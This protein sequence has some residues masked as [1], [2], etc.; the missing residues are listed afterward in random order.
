[1]AKAPALAT[2]ERDSARAGAGWSRSI[3]RE[4]SP[5]QVN[6]MASAEIGQ[7]HL[8]VIIVEEYTAL[9][10]ARRPAHLLQGKLTAVKL[11]PTAP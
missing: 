11:K 5:W 6:E 1:M 4:E 2:R 3:T 7:E 8:F 10:H 9:A